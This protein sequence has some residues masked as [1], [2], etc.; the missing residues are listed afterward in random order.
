MRARF[1]KRIPVLE[2]RP[3][4]VER[5][6]QIAKS[7]KVANIAALRKQLT[8]EGYANAV[9]ALAGR[10]LANAF[11]AAVSAD[12]AFVSWAAAF[13]PTFPACLAAR[14]MTATPFRMPRTSKA[15]CAWVFASL[16]AA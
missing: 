16:C 8:D 13:G 5:A 14:S 9:Q 4:V 1:E 10:S 11:C 3:S 2:N 7:G 12:R 15:I 6:F